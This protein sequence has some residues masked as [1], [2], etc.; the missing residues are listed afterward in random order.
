MKLS[1]AQLT[2][3]EVWEYFMPSGFGKRNDNDL[4]RFFEWSEKGLHRGVVNGDNS[5]FRGLQEG[6]RWAGI[7]M[8][9]LYEQ[10]V[11]DGTMPYFTILGG[12][13][14]LQKSY[15]IHRNRLKTLAFYY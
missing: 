6:K 4:K 1:K 3:I 7:H 13:N 10:G 8:H 9:E 14:C 5:Y 11:L 2:E 12:S 15:N